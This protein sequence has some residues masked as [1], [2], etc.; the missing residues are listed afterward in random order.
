MKRGNSLS[1][2]QVDA[3][4]YR[5]KEGESGLRNEPPSKPSK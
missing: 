3:K 2:P 1:S 5:A 4:I